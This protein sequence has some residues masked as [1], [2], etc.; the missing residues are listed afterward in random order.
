MYVYTHHTMYVCIYIHRHHGRG[1]ALAAGSVRQQ[2]EVPLARVTGLGGTC[3]IV[4]III[5]ILILILI[6]ILIIII[7]TMKLYH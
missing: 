2:I 5:I 4:I 3:E 6:L 7:I 1:G